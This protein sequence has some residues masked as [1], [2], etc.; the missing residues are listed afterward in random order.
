MFCVTH[1]AGFIGSCPIS[2]TLWKPRIWPLQRQLLLELKCSS[3]SFPRLP[4]DPQM[5]QGVKLATLQSPPAREPCR[6]Q[7]PSVSIGNFHLWKTGC[8][9][10]WSALQML[11]CHN[12]TLQVL[13]W[14]WGSLLLNHSGH[15]SFVRFYTQ[16]R[17]VF[18]NIDQKLT[19]MPSFDSGNRPRWPSLIELVPQ[20]FEFLTL[21]QSLCGTNQLTLQII[22]SHLILQFSVKANSA[23]KN[24]TNTLF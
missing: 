20:T 17:D 13:D 8:F 1:T 7:L 10:P 5:V 19:F 15:V 12:K 4:W 16:K 21:L 24:Q 23:Q 14:H 3:F 18:I 9:K 6:P 22:F 2:E 11:K